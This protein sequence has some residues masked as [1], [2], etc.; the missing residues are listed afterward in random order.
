METGPLFALPQAPPLGHEECREL[1]ARAQA[2]D[3]AAKERLVEANL[4]LVMSVARRF[5]G[6]GKE[7]DD[8]F[9]VGC[10]GLMRAIERFDL[11]YEVAFSTYAVPLIVGEIQRYLREDQPVK[12]SRSL[13]SL[14]GRVAEARELLAVRMGRSPTPAEVAEHLQVPKEEV[15]AALEAAVPVKSLDEP[16]ED[17]EG[18]A[19]PLLERV[20][21]HDETPGRIEH[22]ALR[23]VLAALRDDEREFVIARYVRRMSQT[24]LAQL[25]GCSQAHVS[26]MERKI[27]D[28]LRRLWEA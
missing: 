20:P 3:Q 9:Q 27:L 14:A 10:L 8:L 17:E 2:K 28:R 4:R 16:L 6:R 22:L 1:I 15:V 7:L 18:Q 5:G 19:S 13:Q 11:R 21:A 26:R 12:I 23:Q 25:L 24:E